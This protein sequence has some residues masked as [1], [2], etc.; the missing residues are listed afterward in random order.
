M[1]FAG[2]L[3][4]I[5]PLPVFN[6]WIDSSR[7]LG[8][9]FEHEYFNREGNVAFLKMAYVLSHEPYDSFYFG[10]SRTRFGVDVE[11]L[12]GLVGGHWYKL[13][14][15][16]GVVTEHL[17]NLRVLLDHGREIRRVV[18][19][20]DDFVLYTDRNNESDYN[21]RLYPEHWWQWFDFYSFYLFKWPD[22]R[23]RAV[24]S[25]EAHL[26]P[27]QRILDEF[28]GIDFGLDTSVAHKQAL[29]LDLAQGI[30]YAD[31]SGFQERV[32]EEI[33]QF[34]SICRDEGIDLTVLITPRYYKTQLARDWAT[35]AD[36]RRRLAEIHD[37]L[38]FA[39]VSR[40]T[41]DSKFWRETSHFHPEVGRAMNRRIAGNGAD[42]SQFGVRVSQDN[43]DSHTSGFVEK[44]LSKVPTFL[45]SDRR[46]WVHPSYLPEP[47]VVV[48]FWER[49]AAVVDQGHGRA[50]GELMLEV[51]RGGGPVIRLSTTVPERVG[52]S[53]GLVATIELAS[54]RPGGFRL[55]AGSREIG[56]FPL[57]G[58]GLDRL[59]FDVSKVAPGATLTFEFDSEVDV[60]KLMSLQYFRLPTPQTR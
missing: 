54:T 17:H 50:H 12:G 60:V 45:E 55:S 11:H 33:R 39:G 7:V 28:S 51:Q 14:Y 3:L 57:R 5:L 1:F 34:V 27:T 13:E 23:E 21:Y 40:F 56:W 15:P 2:V 8:R 49:G 32:L 26:V 38:D 36:F 44:L 19:S 16:G 46:L 58:G 9:D 37:H 48:D 20:L 41:T 47:L 10:S 43:V 59:T 24:L 18:L 4:A 53:K 25:G 52:E 35:L 29:D 30:Q 22:R 6:L 31:M 42:S